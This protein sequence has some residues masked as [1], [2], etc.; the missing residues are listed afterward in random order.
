MKITF[1]YSDGGRSLAGYLGKTK[2]CVSRSLAIITRLPYIEV[3]QKINELSKIAG[4]K[5]SNRKGVYPATMTLVN[6]YLSSLGFR[7]VETSNVHNL[8]N[9][10]LIVRFERHFAAVVNG[11]TRDT[12]DSFKSGKRKMV[13]YFIKS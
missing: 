11:E 3:Y 8:P 7:F 5:S 13:G 1:C 6:Q 10:E 2:D 4:C 9:G 12:F